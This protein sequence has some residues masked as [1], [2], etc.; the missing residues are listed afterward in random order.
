MTY[1][2]GLRPLQP[3]QEGDSDYLKERAKINKLLQKH[4]IELDEETNLLIDF[5]VE[6]G[7]S[8]KG[9][10]WKGLLTMDWFIAEAV[11]TVRNPNARDRQR[12]LEWLAEITGVYVRDP[13]SQ[14]HQ[15]VDVVLGGLS[16]S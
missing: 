6:R 10:G 16:G 7:V 4:K 12:T 15:A 1:P 9:D 8:A 13:K 2:E 11:K 14:I 3:Q 5:I